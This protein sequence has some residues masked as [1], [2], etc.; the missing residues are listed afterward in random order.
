MVEKTSGLEESSASGPGSKSGSRAT[1][2]PASELDQAQRVQRFREVALPYLDHC[3]TLA[4]YLLRNPD[5][6]DD[7]VQECYLRAFRHFDTWRGDSIK[8]W[9]MAILRN[10][11]RAEIARRSGPVTVGAE[12]DLA[13]DAMPMWQD[14][15]DPPDAEISRSE[16]AR[17]IIDLLEA[18]PAQFRECI[19]LRD[20]NHLS[21]R[22]ISAVL[23]V[24]IGTVM[25][26]LA[27]GRLLLRVARLA[28]RGEE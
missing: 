9:L 27:R 5:D 22:E 17:T 4:R 13:D 6:A 24:P 3:Y 20:V 25:S 21:Y 2:A 8:P 14:A 15:P 18:L 7:A 12:A 10:V 23:D 1:T 26:R 19:V 16:D 28:S 11:C